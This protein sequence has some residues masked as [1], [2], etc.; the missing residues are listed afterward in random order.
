MLTSRLPRGGSSLGRASNKSTPYRITLLSGVLSIVAGIAVFMFPLES[1]DLMF[2]FSGIALAVL[3]GVL[4]ARAFTLGKI[5][6]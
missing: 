3:G 2:V 5:S 6:R 1:V 4:L